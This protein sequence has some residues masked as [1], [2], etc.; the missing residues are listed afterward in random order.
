VGRHPEPTAAILDSQSV[1][2]TEAGGD[3]GFDGATPI[4]GRKRY[5]LVDIVGNVLLVRV[6]SAD[7]P[8]REG[9]KSCS[10]GT[11]SACPACC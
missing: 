1:K 7:T 3:V 4:K 10:G 2:S 8:E 11:A 5:L 6:T 9:R